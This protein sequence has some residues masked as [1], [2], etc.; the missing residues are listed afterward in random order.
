M[1][2]RRLS[3][4]LA[5]SLAAL[6]WWVLV[7]RPDVVDPE[8]AVELHVVFVVVVAL[9]FGVLFVALRFA[10]AGS[11][12]YWSTGRTDQVRPIVGIE[13]AMV[14][15]MLSTSV[16]LHWLGRAD[17]ASAM[18]TYLLTGTLVPAAFLQFGLV[19]WPSR[20]SHPGRLRL[21]LTAGLAI[22]LAAA[23]TYGAYASAP[24]KLDLPSVPDQ[25]VSVVALIIGATFEEIVFR[26]LLLTALLDRTGS[27]FQAAFLSSVAFGLMH[28]PGVLSDPVMH[29][30]W[31]FLQQVAFEYAPEFLAQTL[32]G[33]LL[34][35]LWLRTGSITLIVATHAILNMG[36]VFAYGLLAYG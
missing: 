31:A 22:A 21:F 13:L 5:L 17:P 33:L 25:I 19:T 28:V 16:V 15:A 12:T 18:I 36:N 3:Q 1:T 26:V 14:G 11:A 32:V 35:V 20:S 4:L 9:V 6:M 7:S 8:I 27:R 24:D 29:S 10:T 2:A 30:D 23:W 34:G